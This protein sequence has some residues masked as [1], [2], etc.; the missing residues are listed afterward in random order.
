MNELLELS[1]CL[2]GQL[3][4]KFVGCKDGFTIV[5][6]QRCHT[7]RTLERLPDPTMI[8]KAG[9]AY[10]V[11]QQQKEGKPPYQERFQHDWTIGNLRLAKIQNC[12]RLLDVGCSN[13]AFVNAAGENWGY[14][15]EGL[16]LNPEIAAF[17]RQKTKRIIHESWSTVVGRFDVITYHDVFE[18]VPDPR[19]ELARVF[20]HLRS[21]GLL[22]LDCP[23]AGCTEAAFMDWK[24]WRPEQHL[25]HWTEQTLTVL[26]QRAGFIVQEVDRPIPGKLVVYARKN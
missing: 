19:D 22:V 25:W 21:E 26:V 14:N 2:C 15:A 9:D 17:A 7:L 20:R 24:H 5:Q 3:G 12:R 16:E 6:C 18:H 8:Y 4:F 13:G 23:D 1:Q 11:E 10:H